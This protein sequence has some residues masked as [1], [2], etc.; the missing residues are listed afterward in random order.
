MYNILAGEPRVVCGAIPS[1]EI[2]RQKK[3]PAILYGK[4]KENISFSV[5]ASDLYKMYN[6][7]NF[8]TTPIHLKIDDKEYKVFPKIVDLHPIT[9]LIRHIDFVYMNEKL[10]KI[11]VPIVF[12]NKEKAIGVKRGGFLNIVRR[13]IN[14]IAPVDSILNNI[15]VDVSNMVI[16]SVI[17]IKDIKLD[18]D[19]ITIID[20]LSLSI[21]SII[22]KGGKEDSEDNGE[23]EAAK[24]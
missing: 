21:A 16:G 14:I 5:L 10:Q 6:S 7:K 9:D 18:T 12:Q 23:S 24:K 15:P 13:S 22:G 8:F 4:E 11:L 2:R 20:K 1:K 3:I 19:K 17:K